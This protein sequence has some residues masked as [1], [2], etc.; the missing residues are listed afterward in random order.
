MLFLSSPR[1][2]AQDAGGELQVDAIL[3]IIDGKM[4]DF[5]AAAKACIKAVK[6]RD[7]GTLQYDWFLDEEKGICVVRETYASSSA[8]MVHMGNLAE[9]LPSL[10]ATCTMKV[11]VFGTPSEELMAATAGMDIE[12]Y[13]LFGG[14][15]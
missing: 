10:F 2:I 4:D 3:T 7:T 8:L 1:L 15:D 14:L 5:K 12:V 11:K 13:P 9:E 6:E